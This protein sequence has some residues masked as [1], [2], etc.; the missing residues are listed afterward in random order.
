MLEIG[1]VQKGLRLGKNGIFQSPLFLR[2][3]DK[4]LPIQRSSPRRTV[5][6]PAGRN[7]D[8]EQR[9]E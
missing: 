5:S 4:Y 2:S 3:N 6:R 1:P 9:K 8:R 7:E